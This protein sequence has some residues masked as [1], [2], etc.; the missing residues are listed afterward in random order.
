MDALAHKIK[1]LPQSAGVYHYFDKDGRLLYVGKAKN[2]KNRVKS[3]FRFTPGIAPSPNLSARIFSL[4]S[5]TVDMSWI[6]VQNEHDALI[7]ENS[8]IKQLKPKYNILLRDDKTYP[9]IYIDTSKPFARFEITR[10]VLKE[11]TVKYFGPYSISAASLLE[12]LYEKFPLVQKRSCLHSKKACLF[13]QIKRCLAPCEGKVSKDAYDEIIKEAIAFLSNKKQIISFLQDKMG[14]YAQ[15]LE[16]EKA[17]LYKQKIQKIEK[18]LILSDVDI[19]KLESFDVVAVTA[20]DQ[21]IAVVRMFIR[22]GKLTSSIHNVVKT[23][24]DID[25]KELYLQSILD[26]YSQNMPL[27]ANKIYVYED[28]EDRLLLQK[29]LEQKYQKSITISNPKRGEKK[30]LCE[31]AYANACEILRLENKGDDDILLQLQT[32][33]SLSVTPYRIEVFDNSHIQGKMAVGAMV[34]YSDGKFDKSGYRHYNLSTKDDY[35]QT[36]EVL[37]R[38][39]ESFATNPPPDLW[40][41]DGGAGQLNVAKELLQSCGANVDVIAIAKEKRDAKSYRAKGKAK[42]AIYTENEIIRLDGS[43]RRLQF[44]QLLRDEAHRFAIEFHRKQKAKEDKKISLLQ[45]HGVGEAKL[46][47]L[48]DY[49]DSFQNIQDASLEELCMVVDKKT[50]QSIKEYYAT[51]NTLQQ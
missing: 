35:A 5:Q 1:S 43:D 44:V 19:A 15:K 10:K 40:V 33:L 13:Y 48:I 23:S 17:A 29:T 31:L 42:D 6:V 36:K 8:L 11:K 21:K 14:E 32:L 4:I 24:Q 20:K 7:L 16:F 50:A 28:F 25:P 22:D 30:R 18:T 3:Y 46:K 34:C 12:T 45:A 27:L 51:D 38:R 49:F 37:M 2:L 41:L 26:F 47:R 9:Y 39:I